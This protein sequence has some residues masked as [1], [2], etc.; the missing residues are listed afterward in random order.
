MTPKTPDPKLVE[1]T[2]Q[3]VSEK[4]SSGTGKLPQL[5]IVTPKGFD[6]A[7]DQAFAAALK[8]EKVKFER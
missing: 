2:K 5:K 1:K 8:G 3:A 7:F 4:P 6:D